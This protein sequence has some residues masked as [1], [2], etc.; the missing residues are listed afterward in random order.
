MQTAAQANR[1]RDKNEPKI[2]LTVLEKFRKIWSS[3]NV[4][5]YTW[6][7]REVDRLLF[8]NNFIF[9]T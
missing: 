1:N 3:K 4:F 8:Y 9:T 5:F 7:K 6:P 2:L